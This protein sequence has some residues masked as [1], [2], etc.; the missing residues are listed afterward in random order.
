M[1]KEDIFLKYGINESHNVWDLEDTVSLCEIYKIM[2]NG[3]L[4]EQRWVSINVIVSFLNKSIDDIEWWKSNITVRD[5]WGYL[6][7]VA[8]RLIYKNVDDL[9]V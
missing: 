2:N 1:T 6:Y 7:L 8:K 4:P 3:N 9:L 5:D